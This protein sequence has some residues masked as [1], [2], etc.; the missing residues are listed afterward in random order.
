MSYGGGSEVMSITELALRLGVEEWR[1]DSM[2]VIRCFWRR[3][4]R[5]HWK[6]EQRQDGGIL[7]WK[8]CSYSDTA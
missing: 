8:G 6:E 7:T 5:S 3:G 4:R 2:M 1:A